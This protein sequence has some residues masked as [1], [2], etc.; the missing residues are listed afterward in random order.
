MARP[1]PANV[2]AIG[3][4]GTGVIGGGWACHFLRQGLDLVVY[5]NAL[6]AEA[7]LRQRIA[8]TWP[9]LKQLG[10]KP[11]ASP[12][13][14]LFVGSLEELAGVPIVQESTP[15][16]LV[17]KQ[18]LY[19]KLDSV[20]PSEVIISSSTSGFPMSDIQANCQNPE[21]TVVCHPFTPPHIVPFCEVV[22]GG[23]TDPEVVD[24]AAEFFQLFGKEVTK[25]DK[26]LPGFIGN[27]LQDAVWREA[28]HMVAAGE[29]SV[30]DIDRSIS[31]GPGLRWAIFGPCMNMAMCGGEGGMERMLEHFG[32]SLME[33]WTRLKAPELTEALFSSL[34][35][36]ADEVLGGRSMADIL[37]E[38]DELLIRI[39]KTIDSYREEKARI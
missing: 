9:K 12:D 2:T 29:C 8:D 32:P 6:G 11:G 21:R 39:L 18:A 30:K 25:M 14:L 24:W 4:L 34:V 38:R 13:K 3:L 28:L 37:E 23:K 35:E 15:E 7:R 10:L 33:P 19:A 20:L 31:Y 17:A 5:D 16:D 36:G 27:R 22:G 1:A 26:E